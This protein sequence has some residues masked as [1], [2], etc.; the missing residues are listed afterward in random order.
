[1]ERRYVPVLRD[2]HFIS[3]ILDLMYDRIEEY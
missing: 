1:M 3:N 2:I